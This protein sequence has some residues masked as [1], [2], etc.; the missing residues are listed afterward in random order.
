MTSPP[1]PAL[2]LED[3]HVAFGGK[4]AVAG[5]SLWVP[6]G[7]MF[8]LVGPNGAGKTTSLSMAVGLLRPGHGRSLVFGVDVWQDPITAKQLIGVLPDGLSLPD[9]FTGGELLTYLGRLRG[10][11]EAT[12]AAR[13]D[14]LLAVLGLTDAHRTVIADYSA[15]MTKKIGLASALLHSPRLLVLDEPFESV[16]PVSSTTIRSILIEYVRGGGTVILSS[17]VMATV[18]QLC[19]HVAVI[20]A[21]R[22]A[23]AGTVDQV[24]AGGTLDDAFVRLVGGPA[25]TGGL[26]WLQS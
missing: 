18:A 16:D 11:D 3:L 1:P 6:Q 8:G 19:T 12:I 24:R 23:A 9:Q 21:G 2:L 17:H 15:G 4:P 25:H 13:R 22:V 26:S 14:E 10:M 20:N 5:V 7:S